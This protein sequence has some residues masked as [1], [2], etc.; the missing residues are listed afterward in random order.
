MATKEKQKEYSKR[1]YELHKE[2][3]KARNKKWREEN[4][5]KFYASVYKCRRRKAEELKS[6]EILYPW[7]SE[8]A[9]KKEYAQRS[10][11]ISR[12]IETKEI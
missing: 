11:R 3:V 2:L 7:L 6:K 9:R 1:Y 8:N 4:K 10:R 5:E 12:K